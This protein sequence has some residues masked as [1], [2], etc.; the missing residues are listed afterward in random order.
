MPTQPTVVGPIAPRTQ[1]VQQLFDQIAPAYDALNERLSFGLHRIWKQMTVQ[2]AQPPLGGKALDLCCGSGDLTFRLARAV[3]P[4][5]EVVGLDC[6]GNLLAIAQRKAQQQLPRP[7]IT[8][9]Q[10]DA[11]DLPFADDTFDAVTL[12]YGLRNVADIPRCLQEIQ[13]VLKPGCRAAILDMVQPASPQMQQ[14]QRWYLRTWVVPAARDLGL[15][16]EYAYIGPSIERFPQGPQQV[17]LAQAAGFAEAIHYPL[18][19]GLMGV[20]VLEKAAA[21]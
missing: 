7:P 20:L 12:G 4:Q 1:P 15:E 5:G 10:A 21:A 3:G 18:L 13:R 6:A 17:K 2:W 14:F 19:G 9:V 16:A 11:L 8:W